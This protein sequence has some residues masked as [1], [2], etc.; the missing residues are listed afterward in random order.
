M[1]KMIKCAVSLL[2]C[3]VMTVGLLPVTASAATITQAQAVQWATDRADEH[4]EIN[5]GTGMTQCT[6]FVAMYYWYL[7]GT[8]KV[9]GNAA[10]Y[11]SDASGACLYSLGWT[12][13]AVS[14]AQPGDIFIQNGEPGHVGVIIARSGN[15]LT[16]AAANSGYPRGACCKYKET[17]SS[18]SGLIRPAFTVSLDS[19]PDKTFREYVKRFDTDG[20]GAL[21]QAEIDAVNEIN[22]ENMGIK[23][24]KGIENFTSLR[25]LFCTK[26]ILTG[27]DVSKNTALIQLLCGD[28][29][30]TELVVSNNTELLILNCSRIN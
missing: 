30:L 23:S 17:L 26:N 22:V 15:S 24:L 4:W 13:P 12:R 18:I 14:S 6:E 11:L 27:L 8:Y 3:L 9:Y 2:L 1:R 10:Y 28:N 29:K 21:S 19:F 16:V 7:T 25:Y 20:D 5:D